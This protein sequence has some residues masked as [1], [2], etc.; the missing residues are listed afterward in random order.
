MKFQIEEFIRSVLPRDFE[1]S[2]SVSAPDVR[3]HGD[4]ST[5]VAFAL[6]KYLKKSP[7]EVAEELVLK[8]KEQGLRIRENLFSRVEVDG[9]GFI[10]FWVLEEV[11]FERL[12]EVLRKSKKWGRAKK[13]GLNIFSRMWRRFLMWGICGARLLETL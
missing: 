1:R 5:N 4:Y 3:S 13:S 11:L 7:R 2:I 10:N 9:G 8:I 12:Q 6:A